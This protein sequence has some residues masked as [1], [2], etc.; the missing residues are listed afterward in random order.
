MTYYIQY[1]NGEREDGVDT[2]A[3]A[4]QEARQTYDAS[5][6]LWRKVAGIYRAGELVMSQRVLDDRFEDDDEAARIAAD[7][8]DEDTLMYGSY[9]DQHRLR[10]R[11]VVAL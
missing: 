2:L 3:E 9:E 10:L 1:D 11:D 8:V 4:I 7:E 5:K 6:R